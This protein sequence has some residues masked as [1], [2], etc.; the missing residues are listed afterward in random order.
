MN[1]QS[2][3]NRISILCPHCGPAHELVA[4][5]NDLCSVNPY[6]RTSTRAEVRCTICRDTGR[7]LTEEAREVIRALRPYLNDV[8]F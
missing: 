7:I 6:L 5:L 1:D 2:L 8:P 3:L 4:K